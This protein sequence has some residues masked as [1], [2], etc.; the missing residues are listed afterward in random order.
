[1]LDKKISGISQEAEAYMME[2]PWEGNVRELKN[3]VKSIFSLR[4]SGYISLK[5]IT[6][7]L[8]SH[9]QSHE[10]A[11]GKTFIPLDD[12]IRDYIYKAYKAN[13]F[14]IKKTA[15]IL[16]I[17]RNRLYRQLK[18]FNISADVEDPTGNN[19][20]GEVSGAV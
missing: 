8:H 7:S 15:G 3:T 10:Q 11:M 12:Y 17:S 2:Y 20:P 9:A 14:N 18:A 1:M 6:I 19:A 16:H 13:G 5:D 4:D